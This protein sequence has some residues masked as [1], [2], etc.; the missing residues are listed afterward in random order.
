[1]IVTHHLFQL[2]TFFPS[3]VVYVEGSSTPLGEP[4]ENWRYR[5]RSGRQSVFAV[6]S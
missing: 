6:F 3:K 1:M 2:F 4:Y 5:G